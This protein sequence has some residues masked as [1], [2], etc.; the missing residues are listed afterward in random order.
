MRKLIY[1][2]LITVL[3][4]GC[5][6]QKKEALKIGVVLPLSGEAAM[7]GVSMKK[8]IDLAYS[9]SKNKDNIV[10]IYQDDKGDPKSSVTAVNYLLSQN[11]DVIIGGA[12]SRTAEPIIPIL[13]QN[14]IPVLSPS[15]SA[16]QFDESSSY[17]F[18]LWVS[19]S[20]DGT[21][22]A[23]YII[24]NYPKED[25]KIAVFY[26]GS[27]Y[28]EGIQRVFSKV[29]TV[30]GYEIVFKEPFTEGNIDF[31]SQLLKIKNSRANILFVPG[32]YAE[33]RN[34]L[35]QRI[36]IGLNVTVM[37][38]SGFNDNKLLADPLMQTAIE[39]IMY[40]F[41]SFSIANDSISN[42]RTTD[43]L[44]R[45]KSNYGTEGDVFGANGY[46]CFAL[47]DS[48]LTNGANNSKKIYDF[49]HNIESFQ[50]VGGTFSF[51]KYG[52]VYKEFDIFKIVKGSPIKISN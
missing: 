35:R 8:S 30:H 46:D 28:G 16:T 23:E 4:W 51:D 33:V 38:T 15:A 17:F 5:G 27:V 13:D 9:V 3:L 45:F 42:N 39:G 10:L 1:L 25:T 12:L 50:G 19:D 43:F 22:I 48:A 34:I 41:P 29:L 32:Y 14:K 31:R 47:I 11:V 20:Y 2:T 37:G 26:S 49:L 36:E 44:S 7:Y 21:K 18:R 52:N 40:T 24:K 6:N